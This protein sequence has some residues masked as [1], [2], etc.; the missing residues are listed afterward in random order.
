MRHQHI[1]ESVNYLKSFQSENQDETFEMKF[2]IDKNFETFDSKIL[3]ELSNIH[4]N[5]SMILLFMEKNGKKFLV[6]WKMAG[7]NYFC[8]LKEFKLNPDLNYKEFYEFIGDFLLNQ[9]RHKRI[10][11]FDN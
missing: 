1:D 7:M 3:N 8:I 4:Q 10:G 5:K 9:L 11:E 6:Y 2:T